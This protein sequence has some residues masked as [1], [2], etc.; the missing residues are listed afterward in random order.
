MV[1]ETA[2]QEMAPEYQELFTEI[3]DE[4]VAW[5]DEQQLA[6]EAELLTVFEDEGLVIIYPDKQSF[7]DRAIEANETNEKIQKYWDIYQ[8]V[9][10]MEA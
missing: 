10:N 1:N 3:W 8:E 9:L 7:I 4:L 2:W 5:C 6:Q